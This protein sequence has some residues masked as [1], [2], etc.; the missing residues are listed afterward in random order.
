MSYLI[1]NVVEFTPEGRILCHL[2]NVQTCAC[3]FRS[4]RFSFIQNYA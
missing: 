2:I 4:Q 3:E 1:W